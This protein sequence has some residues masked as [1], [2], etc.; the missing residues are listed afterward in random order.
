MVGLERRLRRI[1]A[2]HVGERPTIMVLIGP[3]ESASEAAKLAALESWKAGRC[4]DETAP[5]V[6]VGDVD[7]LII[8]SAIRRAVTKPGG[9]AL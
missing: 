2:E 9:P 4:D 8:R 3:G 5:R 6:G 7:W 1:E